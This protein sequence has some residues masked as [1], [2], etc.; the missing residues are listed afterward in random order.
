M[1]IAVAYHE[2]MRSVGAQ[3]P[4]K[5]SYRSFYISLLTE[6]GSR[7][8]LEAINIPLLRSEDIFH[9]ALPNSI[10]RLN[11]FTTVRS[12]IRLLYFASITL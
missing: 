5:L 8:R 11:A 2:I 12:L 9:V 4:G 10:D 1:F 7:A 6:R 3:R